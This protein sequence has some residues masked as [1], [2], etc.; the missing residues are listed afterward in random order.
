MMGVRRSRLHANASVS[1]A[2]EARLCSLPNLEKH[3]GCHVTRTKGERQRRE[4]KAFA[5]WGM[6]EDWLRGESLTVKTKYEWTQRTGWLNRSSV[7]LELG[8]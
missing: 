6:S 5:K 2:L 1:H 8:S 7:L 3:A 4:V